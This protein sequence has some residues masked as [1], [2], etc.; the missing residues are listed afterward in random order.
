MKRILTIIMFSAVFL[1]G[2][3]ST[4]SLP[5]APQVATDIPPAPSVAPTQVP[6]VMDT[7]TPGIIESTPT[8]EPSPESVVPGNGKV[9]VEERCSICHSLDRV[10][11][12]HKSQ[13]EWTATVRRMLDH[14]A[15]LDENEQELVIQ[16]LRVTYP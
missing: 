11:S 12:S 4:T 7:A 13:D 9:L 8:S 15:I 10:T 16:Y 14:G 1:S 6:P 3:G 2:C 5:A